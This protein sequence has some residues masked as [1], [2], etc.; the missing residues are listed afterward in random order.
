M[1]FF[2]VL[3]F[4][5]SVSFHQSSELI[6]IYMLILPEEQTGEAWEPYKSN[7]LSEIGE[8]WAEEILSF[9]LKA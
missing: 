1:L 4:P 6:F 9:C 3:R 2:R 5:L 8:H 7:G